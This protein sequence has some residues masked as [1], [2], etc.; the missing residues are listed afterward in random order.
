MIEDCR[1]SSHYILNEKDILTSNH[2]AMLLIIDKSI[3]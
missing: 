2:D 1:Q 3:G